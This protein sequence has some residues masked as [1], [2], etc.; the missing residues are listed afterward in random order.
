MYADDVESAVKLKQKLQRRN[1]AR[2]ERRLV[3][4]DNV[5]RSDRGSMVA[6]LEERPARH[7]GLKV[8]YSNIFKGNY[9]S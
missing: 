9:Y 6:D 7:V 3:G 1:R 2:L 5:S 4:D 8:S